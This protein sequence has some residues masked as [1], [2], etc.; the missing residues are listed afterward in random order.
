MQKAKHKGLSIRGIARGVGIHEDTAKKYMEAKSPPM[1]H[2][3]NVGSTPACKH[4]NLLGG[5]FPLTL[6]RTNSP[7]VDSDDIASA[8]PS[9]ATRSQ[10]NSPVSAKLVTVNCSNMP[11]D[12]A[13][14]A[15][16]LESA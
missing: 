12:S 15:T 6:E 16:Y 2:P 5:H 8:K 9:T 14:T 7:N 4:G 3:R 10:Q 11:L 1:A 13:P